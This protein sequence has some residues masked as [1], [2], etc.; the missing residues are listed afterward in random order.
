MISCKIHAIDKRKLDTQKNKEYQDRITEL[1]NSET[2]LSQKMADLEKISSTCKNKSVYLIE[3]AAQAFDTS[4]SGFS[5]IGSYGDFTILSFGKGKKIT[6]ISGGAMLT[7]ITRIYDDI[8]KTISEYPKA[9]FKRSLLFLFKLFAFSIAIKPFVLN[10]INKFKIS[11][12]D[13]N[14]KNFKNL[15]SFTSIKSSLGII[16]LNKLNKLNG[17]IIKNAGKITEKLGQ[18]INLKTPVVENNVFLRYPLLLKDKETKLY[19][20]AILGNKGI[21][22]STNNF[23]DLK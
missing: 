6:T 9:G 3:D 18:I 4:E 12:V 22:C 11:Y 20:S 19:Y 10:L 16:M 13:T 2:G 5:L 15:Y 1:E 21:L 23:H 14:F 7:N 17:I 8:S